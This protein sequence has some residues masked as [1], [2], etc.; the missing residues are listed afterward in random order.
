MDLAAGT[1]PYWRVD[2]FL[3]PDWAVLSLPSIPFPSGFTAALVP[4]QAIEAIA[5]DPG[6]V[7]YFRCL[8]HFLQP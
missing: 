2:P 3:I 6:T 8:V 5:D 7:V 1:I 4:N